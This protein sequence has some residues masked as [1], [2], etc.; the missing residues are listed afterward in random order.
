[1]TVVKKM[2]LLAAVVLWGTL[3]VQ[4]STDPS[5]L[6]L[7][8]EPVPGLEV[9]IWTD[10]SEYT[11]DEHAR[12]NIWLS[13]NAYV[14]VYN[15]DAHGRVR[16]IFPNW[17]S[18]DPYLRRGTHV[19]PDRP[20]YRLGVTGPEGMDRLQVIAS[21]QPLGVG[22]G[23]PGDPYPL[24][25]PDAQQG[26]AVIQGLVPE[27]S[28]YVTA[29]TTFRVWAKVQPPTWGWPFAPRPPS[30]SP[31]HYP[32]HGWGWYH[33]D[34]D[35]YLFIGECPPEAQFCWRLGAD[36]RWRFSWRIRIG[37]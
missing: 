17:Y 24:L 12:V 31:P 35:W 33:Y 19:L 27:P 7:V 32:P 14:Y 16:Q 20:D 2:I 8:P 6:G 15:I 30:W 36:G 3:A 28:R 23:S 1:M 25:A 22:T 5:P 21:R 4:A 9:S 37:N 26:R 18:S 29:W 11:V 34:G 10:K 13:R